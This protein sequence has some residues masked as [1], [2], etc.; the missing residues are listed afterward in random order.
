MH[1]LCVLYNR[2]IGFFRHSIYKRVN[3]N[4]KKS[5]KPNIFNIFYKIL[6]KNPLTHSQFAHDET[7]EKIELKLPP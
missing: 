4:G 5:H 6:Y 2:K 7:S 1:V 3:L